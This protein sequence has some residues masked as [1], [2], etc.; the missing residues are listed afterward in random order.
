MPSIMV[1]AHNDAGGKT[2]FQLK[3]RVSSLHLDDPHFSAQLL[4]RVAWAVADAEQ[5]ERTGAADSDQTA[6]AR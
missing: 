4:E 3:E 1:V 5:A 6:P 2:A